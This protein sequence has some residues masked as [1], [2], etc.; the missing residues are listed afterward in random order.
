MIWKESVNQVDSKAIYKLNRNFPLFLMKA[1]IF[2]E[3]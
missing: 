2:F 3:A 1:L